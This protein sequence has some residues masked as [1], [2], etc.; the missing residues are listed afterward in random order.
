[1]MPMQQIVE[2]V[3]NAAGQ[4]ADRLHLLG[5]TQRFLGLHELARPFGDPL[6]ERRVEFGQRLR[7]IFLVFDIGIAADPTRDLPVGGLSGKGPGDVPTIARHRRGEGGTALR[8][9][10]R[11]LER[12]PRVRLAAEIVFGMNDAAPPLAIER[13]GCVPLYS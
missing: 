6:F 7:C 11:R 9:A 3:R 12:R 8:R 13:S 10:F 4:L 1:M 2:I 5:L